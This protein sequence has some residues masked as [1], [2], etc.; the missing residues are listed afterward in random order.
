M[1]PPEPRSSTVSPGLSWASAVGLPQ[2]SDALTASSGKTLVCD[3]SY[4]FLVMGSISDPQLAVAPQHELPCPAV[5]RRAASPY[6]SLTTSL[7]SCALM[8]LLLESKLICSKQCAAVQPLCCGCST[9]HTRSQ[10]VLAAPMCWPCSGETCPR[11]GPGPDLHSSAFPD[12]AKA[13]SRGSQAPRRF[14]SPPCPQDGPTATTDR[15]SVV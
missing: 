3:G 8:V 4:K 14:R 12:G 6:F 2:P 11:A 9:R 13:W 10:G 1:P 5:T 15:K 7:I